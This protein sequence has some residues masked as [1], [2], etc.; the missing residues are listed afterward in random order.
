MRLAISDAGAFRNFV[1]VVFLEIRASKV[2]SSG[3]GK[4]AKEEKNQREEDDAKTKREATIWRFW[5]RDARETK[6]IS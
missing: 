5:V 3:G 6:V 1:T 2:G 4:G